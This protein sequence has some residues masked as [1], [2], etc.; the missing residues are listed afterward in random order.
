MRRSRA[1]G[2]TSP[3]PRASERAGSAP[4][5][6]PKYPRPKILVVDAPDVTSALQERGYAA[7]SGSF[8]QPVVVPKAASYLPLNLTAFLPDYTE[9]EIVGSISSGPICRIRRPSCLSRRPRVCGGYGRRQQRM[10]WSTRD[11]LPC[12]TCRTR[13]TGSTATAASLSSSPR[14]V[15]TRSASPT[16]WTASA[17]WTRTAPGPSVPTTGACCRSCAGCR[18]RRHRAGDGRRAEQ[19]GAGSGDRELLQ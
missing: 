18:H 16:L 14:P 1:Q 4:D 11:P 15:S 10:A 19:R 8:G 5:A 7:R 12:C 17:T 13:W 2:T 3:D 9:Q 6:E